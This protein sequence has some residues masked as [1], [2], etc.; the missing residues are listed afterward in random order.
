MPGCGGL[1]DPIRQ[2]FRIAPAYGQEHAGYPPPRLRRE[3]SDHAEVD[4]GERTVVLNQEIP[5]V[6]IGVEEAVLE[7]RFQDEPGDPLRD[8][9]AATVRESGYI[10]DLAS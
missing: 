3:A 6:W 1:D 8:G 5:R 2:T 9:R 7:G 10:A 4:D